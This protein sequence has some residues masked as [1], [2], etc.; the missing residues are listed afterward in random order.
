[1]GLL[2]EVAYGHGVGEKLVELLGHFQPDWFFQVQRE[3]MFDGAVGLNLARSLME[4][5]LRANFAVG[6]S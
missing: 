3:Q 2:V 6:G 4:A 5:R 1:M